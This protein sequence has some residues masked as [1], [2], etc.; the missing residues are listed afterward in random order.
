VAPKPYQKRVQLQL[1][2]DLDDPK[3]KFWKNKD[4]RLRKRVLDV[5]DRLC[6]APYTA[7]G[8]HQLKWDISGLR[9]A[10]LV[11]AWRLIFKVCEECRKQGLQNQNPLDGCRGETQ[12]PNNTINFLEI[13]DYHK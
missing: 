9:A 10:D 4:P 13:T 2:Q 6:D 11:G 1:Q 7:A 5:I 12:L 3:A 8:S